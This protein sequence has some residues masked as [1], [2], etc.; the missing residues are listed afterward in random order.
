MLPAAVQALD[1]EYTSDTFTITI[2]GYTGAGGAVVIP[3]TIDGLPVTRLD[4]GAFSG[5]TTVTSVTIPDSVTSIGNAVFQLCTNMTSVVIGNGLTSIGLR[6]FRQCSSLTS[7]TIGNSVTSIGIQAFNQCTSLATITIPSSV[8]SIG[9]SAFY[10]CTG[11]TGVYFKGNAPTLGLSVFDLIPANQLTVYYYLGTTD[12]PTPPPAPFGGRPTVSLNPPPPTVTTGA[13]SGITATDATLNGTV[14]PNG[15]AST[16]QFEYGLTD[17]YGSTAGV[18]LAPDNGS[19]V[20]AVS[21]S[22][23]GLEAGQI[24]HYR[25]T[26]TNVG[27]TSPGADMTFTMNPPPPTVTTGAASGI[28]ATDATLNGTVNPNGFASTAQFEYG[29]TD[30]YGSTAGVTLAPDNGSS[31]Q[32]VSASIGGL[33]AG[34]VYHYRLTATNVGGTSPGADMTFTMNPP[35]P[36][37]TTDAASGITATD[38]TLNGTVN[39]N[40]F[41]STAQFEYG[42]TDTYGS[43]AGVTL[44]PD[45]GSSV[46]AVSADISGLEAGQIYHYRLTATNVGGTSPGADMT[47]TT[48]HVLTVN[49]LHGTVPGAGHYAPNTIVELAVTANPGYVF[50]EWT[51]DATGTDNPLAVTMDASKTITA[52]FAPDTRDSDSDGLNNYDEVVTYGTNPDLKDTDGDGFDDLFEVNS[53]FDPKLAGSTPDIQSSIRTAVEFRFN[54]AT[55]VSYRIEASTDLITWD[56]IESDIIGQSA[57]VTRFYSTENQPKRFFQAK[58]N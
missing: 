11:L 32:A 6:M 52:N 39:P 15:F 22:I 36:T 44:A 48:H 7:V 1:Y 26:A 24:Y 14:N 21:A 41:A 20:Q 27:G 19:S 50:S 38:A 58:R 34:Q 13:A 49:A 51:G 17:T 40:G 4:N 28:T 31:V 16:A 12:W 3:D 33:E 42:L 54:A 10:S 55:G 18:T 45:N 8:T 47:F 57:V 56:I 2:T 9:D 25:L 23:S 35:P 43:T 29:L 5:R 46:Q 37:V 53:G 30:T